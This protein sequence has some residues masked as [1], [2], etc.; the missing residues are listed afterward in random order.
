MKGCI[1]LFSKANV[2]VCNFFTLCEFVFV[3]LFHQQL[4]YNMTAGCNYRAIGLLPLTATKWY[5]E[6]GRTRTSW[7]SC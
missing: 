4:A 6:T 1:I 7:L 2:G 5:Y 3:H